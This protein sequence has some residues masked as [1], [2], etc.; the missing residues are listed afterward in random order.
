VTRAIGGAAMYIASLEIVFS[1]VMVATAVTDG[2]K[3][4]SREYRR[5]IWDPGSTD[6]ACISVA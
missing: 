6:R 4:G 5:K 2:P 1:G 3:N